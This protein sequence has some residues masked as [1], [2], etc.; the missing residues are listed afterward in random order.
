VRFV[1]DVT[2]DNEISGR[3]EG[4]ATFKHNTRGRE[5]EYSAKKAGILS[6]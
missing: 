3:R 4:Y 1:K 6:E 2:L 5:T